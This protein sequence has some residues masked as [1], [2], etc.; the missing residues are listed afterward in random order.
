MFDRVQILPNTL[1]HVETCLNSTKQG[2]QTEKCFAKQQ[3]FSMFYRKTFTVW[4]GLKTKDV[5]F[6]ASA[7]DTNMSSFLLS[8]RA[9]TASSLA[10]SLFSY[11]F[12]QVIVEIPE[13]VTKRQ[14]PT[15]PDN[16]TNYQ[17]ARRK[18]EK[19]YMAASLSR[20]SLSTSKVFVLGD[21]KT[22]GGYENVQLEPGTRYKAYIRAVTED[23][24]VRKPR[25]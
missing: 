15:L 25:I 1:K 19:F 10:L 3:C 16:V 5:F 8:R 17:E 24:G 7:W 13:K 14:T 9:N 12:H 23:N 6:E 2:G 20:D 22:Y 18:G 11:S 4:T 21:G